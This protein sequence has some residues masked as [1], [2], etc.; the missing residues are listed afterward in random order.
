MP[1][2]KHTGIAFR[3]VLDLTEAAFRKKFIKRLTQSNV[4]RLQYIHSASQ[5]ILNISLSFNLYSTKNKDD[6]ENIN[7]MSCFHLTLTT[8]SQDLWTFLPTQ[9]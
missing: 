3:V 8:S 4:I 5:T 6:C 1:I 2:L 7:S 9:H